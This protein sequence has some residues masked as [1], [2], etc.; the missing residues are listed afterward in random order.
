MPPGMR[1]RLEGNRPHRRMSQPELDDVTQFVLV[2]APLDRGHQG[3]GQAS[4]GAVIQRPLLAFT[5]IRAADLP[6]R[7][8]VE[9]VE[10]QI[11]VDRLAAAPVALPQRRYEAPV[12]G[13]PDAVGV[14]VDIADRLALRQV[15]ELQDVPVNGGFP[16]GEHHHLRLPFR[17]DEHVQHLF[18]LLDGDGI[19]VGLVTGV[20]EA[21]R[22]V[23]V[24][25]GVDL[26]DPQAGV[27]L[28]LRAQAAVR[29][30][31]VADLGLEGQRDCPG[32]VEPGR[33]QVRL[34]VAVDQ[35]LERPVL[36]AA[37]TQVYPVLADVDLRVEDYLAHRAD[38]L[39]V[40]NEHLIPVPL[41]PG[42]DHS[43]AHRD[44]PPVTST[45]ALT[46]P[47]PPGQRTIPADA[48]PLNLQQ[49]DTIRSTQPRRAAPATAVQTGP[50]GPPSAAR[51]SRLG[52]PNQVGDS[53]VGDG[54]CSRRTGR[55]GELG[56]TAAGQAG[57]RFSAVAAPESSG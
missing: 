56:R 26:D 17:G 18:A 7:T 38:A 24:A 25:A 33:A 30:A 55:R 45:S 9:S 57:R 20:G 53:G 36:P 54:R 19:A 42:P 14:E 11:D 10:L 23:Q 32:L 21:D 16:A 39:G 1:H 12:G 41:A 29:R 51:L 47:G 4:L 48:M 46:P 28:V 22:A 52:E 13:Q 37:L 27:L 49:P 3:H 6:V 44:P 35:R 31:A 2:Q 50:D 15:D 5:Q 34:R 8:F 43:I 40:L